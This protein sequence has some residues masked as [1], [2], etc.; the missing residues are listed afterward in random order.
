MNA[1]APVYRPKEAAEMLKISKATLWRYVAAGR[2][3][4]RKI[5]PGVTVFLHEDIEEFR[6]GRAA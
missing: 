1:I 3:P 4:A 2:L 6:R 5:G